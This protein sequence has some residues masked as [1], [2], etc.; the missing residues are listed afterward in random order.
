M[1]MTA[2]LRVWPRV[3]PDSSAIRELM[4]KVRT[5]QSST[6]EEGSHQLENHHC[7]RESAEVLMANR[8][9]RHSLLEDNPCS[10]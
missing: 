4:L 5:L 2:L 7:A 8:I 1:L 3:I 10:G 6:R 9:K